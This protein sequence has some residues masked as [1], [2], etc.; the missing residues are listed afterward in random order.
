M[1]GEANHSV[2]SEEGESVANGAAGLNGEDDFVVFAAVGAADVDDV[3][4]FDGLFEGAFAEDE[5]VA[6][7]DDFVGEVGDDKFI[8]EA[9]EDGGGSHGQVD[10]KAFCV[11]FTQGEE[12]DAKCGDG[13]DE[14]QHRDA[15]FH[16]GGPFGGDL[17]HGVVE[18]RTA[19]SSGLGR[20]RMGLG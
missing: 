10:D 15:P 20:H 2:F 8:N 12:Q 5:V 11:A 18:V 9:S 16:E 4:Q 17:F 14:P 13:G 3:A 7:V 1:F 6:V 19:G